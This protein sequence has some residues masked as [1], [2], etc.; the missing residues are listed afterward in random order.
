VAETIPSYIIKETLNLL[1]MDGVKTAGPFLERAGILYGRLLKTVHPRSRVIY[2]DISRNGSRIDIKGYFSIRSNDLGMVLRHCKSCVLMAATLGSDVDRLISRVQKED[3]SDA[4]LIDALA[5]AEIEHLCD[6]VESDLIEKISQQEFLTMR[7]SPGY[8]DLPLE[9]SDKLLD[10]LN[11]KK[12]IGINMTKSFM[13]VPVK[14][15]TAIIGISDRK[16]SRGRN[17]SLCSISEV[18]KYRKGG[19]FCGIQDN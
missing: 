9:V 13:L 14:S 11:A 17:C 3:M 10:A 7:F 8:G 19:V 1:G 6:T 4:V 16:E 15:V 18:C 12:E 5:S 2:S